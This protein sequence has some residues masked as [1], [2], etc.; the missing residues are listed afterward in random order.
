M[1]QPAPER[2]MHR[3]VA[4][5]ASGPDGIADIK[6]LL[7]ALP[8]PFS[9]VVMVVLHRAA[10]QISYLRSALASSTAMA[11]IVAQEGED[12][13]PGKV[14]IG[15]PAQ[16]LTLLAGAAAGLVPGPRHEYRNRTIDLLFASLAAHAGASAV[17]VVLS[18]SLDDGSRGLA[19]IHHA[20]GVTMVLTPERDGPAG[21]PESAIDYAGP[22]DAIGSPTVIARGIASL[23]AASLPPAG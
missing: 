10:D 6:E 13:E 15:E 14:Y 2:P 12:L 1:A 8:H 21:M 20:G 16:H 19:A 5:G 3:Y 4:I 7:R 23:L 17:G 22:I 11:V 9:A 18:G